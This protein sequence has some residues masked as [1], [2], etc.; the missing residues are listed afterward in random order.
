MADEITT[1][2]LFEEALE[3]FGFSFRGRIN[4]T[5]RWVFAFFEVDMVVEL[6][7]MIR[8]FVGFGLTEDVDKWLTFGRNL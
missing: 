8:K 3:C 4:W 6:W 7:A 5:K 1:E 2:I